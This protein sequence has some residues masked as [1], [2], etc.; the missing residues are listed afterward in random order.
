MTETEHPMP[1]QAVNEVCFYDHDNCDQCPSPKIETAHLS[2]FA[3][4][5]LDALGDV[6]FTM[7]RDPERNLIWDIGLQVY[8]AD[9]PIGGSWDIEHSAQV[10]VPSYIPPNCPE[11]LWVLYS[12]VGEMCTHFMDQHGSEETG[13]V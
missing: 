10:G 12:A 6:H 8:S 13:W 3:R 7:M 5:V 9:T 11:W 4:G 2:R 1:P